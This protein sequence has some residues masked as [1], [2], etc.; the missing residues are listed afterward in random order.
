MDY[1]VENIATPVE[2]LGVKTLIKAPRSYMPYKKS[3][4]MSMGGSMHAVGLVT[5][6]LFA[7]LMVSLIRLVWKMGDKK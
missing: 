3:G 4:H 7:A 5:W 6:L 2:E 1:T